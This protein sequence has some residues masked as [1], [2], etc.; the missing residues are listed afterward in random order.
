[1][2]LGVVLGWLLRRSDAV[3]AERVRVVADVYAKLDRAITGVQWAQSPAWSD[4][5]R[6]R[7]IKELGPKCNAL[8]D[9]MQE[10]RYWFTRRTL[11][12]WDA[13]WHRLMDAVHA[14]NDANGSERVELLKTAR[15]IIQ[16]E[17]PL[18][19]VRVERD[20]RRLVGTGLW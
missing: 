14:L 16:N 9:A 13:I 17:L 20:C 4:D 3:R 19:R 2:L 15:L 5:E 7:M 18:L 11:K 6:Q 12:L 8:R 10:S 1:M